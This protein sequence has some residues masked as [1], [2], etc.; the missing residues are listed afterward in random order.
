MDFQQLNYFKTVAEIGKISEAAEALFISAPALSTSISRLEKEL[1]V[2]LFDRTNN[3][4]ILNEQGQIFLGH[5]RQ[6][7]HTMNTAKEELRQYMLQQE[8]HL[9]LVCVNSTIWVNLIT[10]FLSEYPDFTLSSTSVRPTRLEQHGLH[11]PYSFLLAYDSDVP[12]KLAGELGSIF[13]FQSIPMVAVHED[14][15]LARES[16]ISIQMLENEKL[17][18]PFPEHSF[19][20]RLKKLFDLCNLSLPTDN[21]YSLVI[22]LKMVSENKGVTFVSSSAS[23]A[24]PA[25]RVR[26]I[27]LA[28]PYEPWNARLYW[29]KDRPLTKDEKILRDFCQQFYGTLHYEDVMQDK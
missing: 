19:F 17:F 10:V 4:I 9:S 25:P 26:Y 23:Q 18:L 29:R 1:G 24:I 2:Q 13:L 6:M 3:R 8:H 7:L 27:P 12:E 20:L 28:A 21:G 11:A 16:E 14:H 15:P 22:R 5:V